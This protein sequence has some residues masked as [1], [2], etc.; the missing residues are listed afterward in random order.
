MMTNKTYAVYAEDSVEAASDR[1]VRRYLGK[2]NGDELGS[3]IVELYADECDDQE[4]IVLV[5]IGSATK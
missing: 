2:C 3:G 1:T 5:P 4:E